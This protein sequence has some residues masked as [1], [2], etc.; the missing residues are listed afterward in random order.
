MELSDGTTLRLS[1]PKGNVQVLRARDP[2][3]V[4]DY[5]HYCLEVGLTFH[6][7]TE[8][9]KTPDRERILGLLK[10]MMLQLRGKNT[11]AKY[12]REILRMLVQQYSVMGLRE[13]CQVLQSCFVNLKGKPGSHIPA[14]LLQEWNVKEGKKH[15]KHMFSNK[16]EDNI[17]RRTAAIPSISAVARNFDSQAGTI[18]RAKKHAEKSSMDDEQ[19]MMDDLHVIKPFNHTENREYM[20]F[21]NIPKSQVQ[22]LDGSKVEQWFESN[23]W[24]FLV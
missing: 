7:F 4:K 17:F 23:K 20:Q 13:A 9:L 8:L 19:S 24:C 3:K 14:D 10:M 2:D 5:A 12:P 22:N 1:I 18:I 6:Y 11:K 16:T 21:R 15:I